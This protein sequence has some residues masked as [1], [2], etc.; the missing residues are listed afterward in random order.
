MNELQAYEL[1]E[2]DNISNLSE[3]QRE[4]FKV[5]NA[6]TADWVFRKILYI[7]KKIKEVEEIAQEE[8]NRIENWN[9]REN[10]RYEDIKDFFESLIINHIF[11][12]KA[13]D[14]SYKLSTPY[15]SAYMKAAAEKWIYDEEMVIKWLD[16]NNK[17]LINIKKTIDKREL[18]KVSA[19]IDG[20]A[21]DVNTGE[22]IEGINIEPGENIVVIK[23]E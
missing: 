1:N 14:P 13:I 8:I 6:K 15:G 11:E 3:E 4:K 5:T 20:N 9:K 2:L 22:V 10:Q 16:K 21:I 17:N 12:Q 19:V 23:V 18:K 7:N